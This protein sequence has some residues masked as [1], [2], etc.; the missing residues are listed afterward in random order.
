MCG[1]YDVVVVH[2]WALG[3][4]GW[5]ADR[6]LDTGLS[7]IAPFCSIGPLSC[8]IGKTLNIQACSY[9][10]FESVAES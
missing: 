5:W 8:L 4:C 7:I 10:A 1:K 2:G 6:G 3:P 9:S